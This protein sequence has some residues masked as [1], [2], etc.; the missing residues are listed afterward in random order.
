MNTLKVYEQSTQNFFN[1]CLHS[2]VCV[3]IYLCLC[4]SDVNI[5]RYQ[6][7][8]NH[9][10]S[11]ERGCVLQVQMSPNSQSSE[12]SCIAPHVFQCTVLIKWTQDEGPNPLPL[13]NENNCILFVPNFLGTVDW[14][15]TVNRT[16][17]I[18]LCLT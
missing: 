12:C 14:H 9:I 6:L 5:P 16:F 2:C 10:Q 8:E 3:Y 7:C 17:L 18:R 15:D 11:W 4:I 13:N 1:C